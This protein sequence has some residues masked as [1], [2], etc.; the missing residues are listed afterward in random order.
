VDEVKKSWLLA[1]IAFS[2]FVAT[3][4]GWAKLATM[5][6]YTKTQM[7][8]GVGWSTINL[9]IALPLGVE[10]YGALALAVAMDT[11]ARTAARWFAGISAVGALTLAAIGQAIVHNLTAAG[12]T[13]ASPD[14]ISFVSVLPVIV[15]GLASALAALS[16][17]RISNASQAASRWSGMAGRLAEAATN[18]AVSRLS[19]PDETSQQDVPE[20]VEMVI[21]MSPAVPVSSI[22]AGQQVESR[23][24]VPARTALEKDPGTI[25][26]VAEWLKEEPYPTVDEIASRLSTSR[27][28]A[29][30]VAKEARSMIKAAQ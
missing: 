27:S 2:A 17:G 5:T 9:G 25:M 15:L 7:I 21:P 6:G 1:P 22:P 29:G 4:G 11:K 26:Q 3:W 13:V 24:I 16:Q 18:R 30:R 20:P 28:T 10:A 14:V 12:K 8:P 19:R 23:L